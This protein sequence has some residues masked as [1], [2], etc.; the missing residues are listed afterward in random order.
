MGSATYCCGLPVNAFPPPAPS[1]RPHQEAVSGWYS[2][3][4][5]VRE[6][7]LLGATATA[8]RLQFGFLLLLMS[9]QPAPRLFDLPVL[10]VARVVHGFVVPSKKEHDPVA[11]DG[12][13]HRDEHLDWLH[14]RAGPGLLRLGLDLELFA[15]MS[16]P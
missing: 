16:S 8:L 15:G 10:T 11:I 3:L 2:L 5:S 9:P 7:L 14:A 12:E 4:G 6:H 13:E 1:A